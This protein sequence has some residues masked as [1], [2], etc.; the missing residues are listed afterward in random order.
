M[1][2]QFIGHELTILP[3]SRAVILTFATQPHLT[4]VYI[5][6]YA[7]A[8]PTD[9]HHG[10]SRQFEQMVG[11]I[12]KGDFREVEGKRIQRKPWLKVCISYATCQ[13]NRR[14]ILDF[15]PWSD[16]CNQ[17]Y[18]EFF[19]ISDFYIDAIRLAQRRIHEPPR[20]LALAMSLHTRLGVGSPFKGSA[21]EHIL[22]TILDACAQE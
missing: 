12:E 2:F 20:R 21:G 19:K 18:V 17:T 13:K 5:P 8:E 11:Y 10:L 3:R 22:T 4:G 6:A 9:W 15:Y 14:M 16:I 1:K 7:R